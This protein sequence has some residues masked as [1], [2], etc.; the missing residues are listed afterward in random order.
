MAVIFI[1]TSWANGMELY[2][3]QP[4]AEADNDAQ[5]KVASKISGFLSKR[6]FS[7]ITLNL[8]LLSLRAIRI[9]NLRFNIV[10]AKKSNKRLGKIT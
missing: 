1:N 2:K 8:E 10:V 3:R 9:L 7:S 4:I 5:T 6:G